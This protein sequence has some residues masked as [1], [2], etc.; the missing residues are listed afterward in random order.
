MLLISYCMVTV[1]PKPAPPNR[2]ILP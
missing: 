2:P 1:L